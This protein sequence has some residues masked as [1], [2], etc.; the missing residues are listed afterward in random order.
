M[1]SALLA[2]ALSIAAIAS[3]SVPARAQD[4]TNGGFHG[5]DFTGSDFSGVFP[6]VTQNQGWGIHA[7]SGFGV[8]RHH[9]DGDH[10]RRHDGRFDDGV[11][12]GGYYGGEW[13]L[14]NNRSWEPDSFNDWWH[15]N[16]ERAY[17]A[18]MQHNQ[19]CDRMW[20]RG[21]TLVC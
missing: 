6:A 21:D 1:K 8:G 18:W 16:P 14:Y 12:L 15:D 3:P 7:R 10:H 19:H 4:F 5:G 13:A 11:V 2:A 17:P 20:Y 9:H